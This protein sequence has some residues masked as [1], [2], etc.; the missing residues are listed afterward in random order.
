MRQ[1]TANAI[2]IAVGSK[3][4]IDT[5]KSVTVTTNVTVQVT[6]H[7]DKPGIDNLKISM[8]DGT[9]LLFFMY[10]TKNSDRIG[11]YRILLQL[12]PLLY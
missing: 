12:L 10:F 3:F 6:G 9:F 5:V 11:G 1:L 8:F 7:K 2:S 4:T